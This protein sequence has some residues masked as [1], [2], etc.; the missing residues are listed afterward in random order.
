MVPRGE[1]V[2]INPQIST[3]AVYYFHG[4]KDYLETMVLTEDDYLDFLVRVSRDQALIPP[5]IQEAIAGTSLLFIGYGLND[6]NFRVIF[7]GLVEHQK[8]AKKLSVTVQLQPGEP[9]VVDYLTKYFGASGLR[10]YWGS[11][12]EFVTELKTRWDAR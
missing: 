5:R 3:P 6:T 11:A 12:C 8:S 4:H 1:S 7:R 2:D 10:V 9:R